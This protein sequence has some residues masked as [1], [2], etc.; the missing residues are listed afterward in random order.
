MLISQGLETLLAVLLGECQRDRAA[1]ADCQA[2]ACVLPSEKMEIGPRPVSLAG[3]THND[4][5]RPRKPGAS[6]AMASVRSP[7]CQGA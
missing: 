6:S 1:R 7:G 3:G 2:D 4:T 5:R